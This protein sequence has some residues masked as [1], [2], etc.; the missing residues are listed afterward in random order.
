[1]KHWTP[2]SIACVMLIST[3]CVIMLTMEAGIV[4][5]SGLGDVQESRE[6]LTHLADIVIGL[7]AGFFMGKGTVG[8]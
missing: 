8:K 2:Q 7:T 3:V 4:C 1:M 6:L 5:R